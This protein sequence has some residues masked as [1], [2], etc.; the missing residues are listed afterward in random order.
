MSY[1]IV[2]Y[3][4]YL[5][6]ADEIGDEIER[7]AGVDR[8][9]IASR[10]RSS[11]A[12]FLS[13]L[14]ETPARQLCELLRARGIDADLEPMK[15]E[16]DKVEWLEVEIPKWVKRG[17]I[18]PHSVSPLYQNYGMEPPSRPTSEKMKDSGQ[19]IQVIYTLG[20]VLVGL[21][22][23]L[24]VA[25]NWQR[26]PPAVKI[27]SSLLLTLAA[28]HAAYRLKFVK[29]SKS[30]LVSALF[31]LAL[32][33]IGGVVILISQTYH[34]QADSYLLPAVWGGLCVPVGVFLGFRPA[35]HLASGLWLGSYWLFSSSHAHLPWF[36]PV[37]LLGFLMPYSL[38]MKD[39]RLY[40]TNLGV[41][42]LA[43][44]LTPAAADIW[45][46]SV[47]IVA[48]LVLRLRFGTSLY[49]GLLVA[50][51]VFWHLTFLA[52]F[53]DFPNVFYAV[54]LTY[55]L[56]LGLRQRSNPLMIATVLN[57]L[58]WLI[59]LHIQITERVD[60][61]QASVTGSLLWMMAAGILCFAI[62]K[63]IERLDEWQ[64]LSEALR[65]GGVI[66]ANLVVYVL[67]FR[68]YA[69][70]TSFFSSPLLLWTA[71]GFGAAAMVLVASNMTKGPPRSDGI[72]SELVLFALMTFSLFLS[73]LASPALWAHVVLFNLILFVEA[74][75]LM[76]R[77]HRAQRILWY[78]LGIAVFV[79]L[80]VSRYLDT[81]VEFLPRSVF[82]ALGGLFLIGWA[83]F[84]ERQR[85]RAALPGET[86]A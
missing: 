20:A 82:F 61:P 2:L 14:E 66:V 15:P 18:F 25:S 7:I 36:Y 11:P 71:R 1:R 6:V 47:L 26:I 37:L 58:F 40:R 50:G 10:L 86:S 59:T 74:F 24:F 21:G 67:S 62:G 41:L 13:N 53:S 79:V 70:E 23:I 17:L 43:L 30:G 16:G 45:M 33:G 68:F 64:P 52:R 34:V 75:A 77:G 76:L 81:F 54:P 56:Y 32:L 57:T 84:V 35:L 85:R 80:T 3:Q 9:S 12:V 63:R 44:A 48:L 55:F 78:N 60:L 4:G 19:L 31:V 39:E 65:Y 49:D 42:M 28:L 8:K 69:D 83:A 22:L 5:A 72:R 38:A 46:C 27:S 29:E 73:S 51:F